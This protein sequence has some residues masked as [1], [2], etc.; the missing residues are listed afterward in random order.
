MRVPSVAW[1]SAQDYADI[2]GRKAGGNDEAGA[3]KNFGKAL[4]IDP[5]NEAANCGMGSIYR[6]HGAFYEAAKCFEK[7]AAANPKNTEAGRLA[8]LC[9]DEHSVRQAASIW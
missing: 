8:R 6:S 7:A 4:S 5:G 2:A 3:A 1:V 9:R